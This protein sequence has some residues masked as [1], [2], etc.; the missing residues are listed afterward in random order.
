MRYRAPKATNT[1]TLSAMFCAMTVISLY[2]AAVLPAMR[3]TMYF[4][5]SLFIAGLIVERKP[6]AAILMYI[7]AALLSLLLTPDLMT[8]LPY[9][10]LFGH[11]GIGKY[12]IEKID[13]KIISYV[14]KLLYF[15]A[16]F[17][18]VYL[19][20]KEVFIGEALKKIPEF[21]IFILIQP[22]FVVFDFVYSFLSDFYYSNIRKRIIR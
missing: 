5:S 17:L 2:L 12:Y 6:A 21:L 7:A 16:C 1:I 14:L 22:V 3:I 10:L 8:T 11:Y 18:I 19:L 4:L 13:N 20:A 15:N 9:V